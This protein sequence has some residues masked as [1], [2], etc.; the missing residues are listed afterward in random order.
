MTTGTCAHEVLFMAIIKVPKPPQSAMNKDRPIS[1]LLKTQI[2]HLQEAEFRLPARAQTNIYINAIKTEG[3]AADYIRQV[4]AALHA[5]HAGV[6]D[7]R[8]PKKKPRTSKKF[9]IAAMAKRPAGQNK[10][11]RA[12][13]SRKKNTR[14]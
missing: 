11:R 1:S 3:Q 4:T 8:T 12:T 6:E 7:R 5:E 2:E 14:S 13:R 10:K 9:A